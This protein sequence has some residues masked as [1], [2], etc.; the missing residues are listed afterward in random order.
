MGMYDTVIVF[1]PNCGEELDFQSKAGECALF[2][3]EEDCVPLAIAADI[4]GSTNECTICGTI[5]RV[6]MPG[7][8]CSVHMKV[9]GE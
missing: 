7:V 4:H 2:F 5:V 8:T 9:T 3:Y 6:S 1:C